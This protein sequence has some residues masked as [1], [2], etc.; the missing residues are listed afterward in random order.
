MESVELIATAGH[1][2]LPDQSFNLRTGIWRHRAARNE[3]TLGLR[4]ALDA[5]APVP[6]AKQAG[7]E[8]PIVQRERARD[9]LLSRHE[10]PQSP[11]RLPWAVEA[12]RCF[13]LPNRPHQSKPYDLTPLPLFHL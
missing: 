13:P 12:L 3:T 11:A 1:R 2:F 9:L 6:R 8:V 4:G 7:E 5:A 10:E